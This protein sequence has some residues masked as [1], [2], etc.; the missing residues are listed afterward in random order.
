MKMSIVCI[1]T[2]RVKINEVVT[3]FQK[4]EVSVRDIQGSRL[5]QVTT[6]TSKRIHSLRGFLDSSIS[7]EGDELL[8]DA[9]EGVCELSVV[10]HL[11]SLLDPLKKIRSHRFVIPDHV[12]VIAALVDD[13]PTIK[14]KP[15][16]FRGR[17]A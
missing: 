9:V 12:I 3:A 17:N 15:R 10:E 1:R 14:T 8:L 2:Y 11:N 6:P 13:L 5:L 7:V 4:L 16:R